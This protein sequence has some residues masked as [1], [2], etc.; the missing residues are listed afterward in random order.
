MIRRFQFSLDKVLAATALVCAA[1]WLIRECVSTGPNHRPSQFSL[2]AGAWILFGAITYLLGVRAAVLLYAG[3]MGVAVLAAL[4]IAL[5][6]L[7]E[8]YI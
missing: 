4:L 2:A 8:L 7:L 1:A 5:R 6:G 3:F